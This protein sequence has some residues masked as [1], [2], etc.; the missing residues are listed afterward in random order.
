MIGMFVAEVYLYIPGAGHLQETDCSERRDLLLALEASEW[1]QALRI[2]TSVLL[3]HLH[4]PVL[5][6][7]LP[8]AAETVGDS[9]E[10]RF[11]RYLVS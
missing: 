1:C 6:A 4:H 5:L 8:L 11:V 10:E 3:L 9:L 2:L 7:G